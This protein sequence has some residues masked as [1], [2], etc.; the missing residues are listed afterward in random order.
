M[1]CAICIQEVEHATTLGCGHGF[2]AECIQQSGKHSPLMCPLCPL[3]RAPIEE[4]EKGLD[5]VRRYNQ[6]GVLMGDVAVL[7]A[8]AA[9]GSMQCGL[10]LANIYHAGMGVPQDEAEAERWWLHFDNN[11][12]ACNNIA[13]IAHRKGDAVKAE[14]YYRKAIEIAPYAIY[15]INLAQ[16]LEGTDEAIQN[17]YYAID[18]YA[19]SVHHQAAVYLLMGKSLYKLKRPDEA[20]PHLRQCVQLSPNNVSALLLLAHCCDDAE[21]AH[22][23]T[24]TVLGIDSCNVDALC[25]KG[26]VYTLQHDRVGAE[27]MMT[28][29]S[30]L[31]PHDKFTKELEVCM[32]NEF[33]PPTRKRARS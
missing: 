17:Y 19:G 3:C 5:A 9:K 29:L 4:C 30:R 24:A 31:A 21:E 32:R 25:I 27:E 26:R 22:V 18:M 16:L 2:H 15:Y 33:G 20:L 13:A 7:K 14:T 10:L 6:S 8:G 12:S 28:R 1:E 23:H 11:A